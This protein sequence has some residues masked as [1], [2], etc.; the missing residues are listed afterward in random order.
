MDPKTA[1]ANRTAKTNLLIVFFI[2]RTSL[3]TAPRRRQCITSDR[4]ERSPKLPN[5]FTTTLIVTPSGNEI[6]KLFLP[7]KPLVA[8][9][10]TFEEAAAFATDAVT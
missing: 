1:T 2:S 9:K 7:A 10:Y 6:A 5:H 4:A 3:K 8:A